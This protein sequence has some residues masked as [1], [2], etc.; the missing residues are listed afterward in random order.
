[1]GALPG[2]LALSCLRPA[3]PAF[4]TLKEKRS[5]FIAALFPAAGTDEARAAL[6]AVRLEHKQ[7]THNCPA[8]RIGFPAVEEFSSDDGEPS[9]TAG[10]PIL[11]CLQKVGLCNA[12][13]V[14]TRYFG[15]VKLGVR[16]LIDA[17]SAAAAGVIAQT[18]TETVR[19][20]RQ[21][22]LHSSY[23]RISSL[24]HALRSSGISDD[25]VRTS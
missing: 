12:V 1:M 25:R 3:A 24:S 2:Q 9:G 18:R 5:E 11:G 19:P 16:G 13:L 10:R 22:R 8:W 4:F 23:D 6:D 7:A 17:Y 15:G 14:V 20:F 21:L